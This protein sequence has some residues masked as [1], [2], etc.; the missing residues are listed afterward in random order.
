MDSEWLII[1]DHPN[2]EV[3]ST[4]DVRNRKTGRILSKRVNN[5]GYA[6]ASLDGKEC[7][8]HRLVALAFIPNPNG[9][10]EINHKDGDKLNN[11][12]DNLEW[13]TRG[14]NIQHAYEHELRSAKGE[15]NA[16]SKLTKNDVIAIRRSDLSNKE[17]GA[18]YGVT[19]GLVWKLRR[20]QYW[21]D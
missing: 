16:N 5:A 18:I 6:R 19:S 9:Y 7:K 12:V 1:S 15:R 21:V 13:T 4:G 20:G 11:V 8:V 3:S 10:S 2:Y 17:L 14:K